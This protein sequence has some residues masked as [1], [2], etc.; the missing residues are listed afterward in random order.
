[1]VGLG[2]T[3]IYTLEDEAFWSK[4]VCG[5]CVNLVYC[6]KE[7]RRVCSKGHRITAEFCVDWVDIGIEN[8]LLKLPNGQMMGY[9]DPNN[10]A[11]CCDRCLKG[12]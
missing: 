4:F 6:R 1:M 9:Y 11:G 3:R 12:G 5:T 2:K 10:P 8:I 7:K